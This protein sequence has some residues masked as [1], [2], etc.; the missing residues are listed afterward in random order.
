MNFK[1]FK[2]SSWAVDN[3]IS[4]YVFTLIITLMGIS[5][6]NKI[7]KE[8]FPDIVI[9]TIYINAIYPGNSP[10]NIENLVTKPIEKQLKGISGVKKI[11]ST[12]LQDVSVIMVEF[13]T[14]M[15]VSDVKQKVKDAV[16][17]AE[18]D[19]P[20]DLTRQPNVMEVNFSELPILYINL[21]GKMD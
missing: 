6:Y 21:A 20:K 7:P 2:P 13:N 9:P 1:Q 17:K 8:S 3:K 19:L 14:N 12:S 15:V 16:D 10:A 11:N 4:I 5:S 18:T